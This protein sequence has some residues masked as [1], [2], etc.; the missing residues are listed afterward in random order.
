MPDVGFDFGQ[1]FLRILIQQFFP[2]KIFYQPATAG[3]AT[4]KSHVILHHTQSVL[5][6]CKQINGNIDIERGQEL[7][8]PATLLTV[9][10]ESN[11]QLSYGKLTWTSTPAK[12]ATINIASGKTLTILGGTIEG[13]AAKGVEFVAETDKDGK[14]PGQVRNIEG[15]VTGCVNTNVDGSWWTGAQPVAS[16]TAVSNGQEISMNGIY[17]LGA[18]SKVS[19]F[20][21]GVTSVKLVAGTG[22]GNNAVTIAAN[23]NFGEEDGVELIIGAGVTATFGEAAS[24]YTIDNLETVYGENGAIIKVMDTTTITYNWV[25]GK[26][27]EEKADASN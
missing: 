16:S 20:G 26:W 24:D 23:C 25:N 14:N 21:T 10:I 11:S 7:S 1:E 5:Y 12:V 22:E 8:L 18:S 15:T 13:N 4:P 17:T 19:N 6:L 27:V 3:N 9:N 2:C